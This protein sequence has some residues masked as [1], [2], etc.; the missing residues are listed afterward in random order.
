MSAERSDLDTVHS[1]H[2][3]SLTVIG[4]EL[5]AEGVISLTLADPQGGGLP[6]WAPG[7]HIDLMLDEG[8][9]RQY[10]L[11]GSPADRSQWRIAVL[12]EPESRGGSTRV[13]GLAVGD[14][15]EVRGPRNNF[16]LAPAER[17]VFVAGG[18]GVT[19]LLP[20]VSAAGADW[21]MWYGGRSRASMAFLDELDG[22]RVTVWPQDDKGLLPLAEIVASLEEGTLVYCCGPEPL[23]EA[24]EAV[25]PPGVLHVERFSP[26]AIEPSPEGDGP[27][28]VE[29][30]KSGL[31]V[32]VPA[33]ATIIEVLE[34]NGLTV[35]TSCQEGVCG[36]CETR[37]LEGI[38]DHRD[39]L[40]TEEER[41]ENEYMMVCVGRSRTPR[42]VLDL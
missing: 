27:F 12:L 8:L 3:A 6:E 9:V 36:T 28:E 2:R 33:G 22:E 23:I 20:M 14:S 40:L 37:V 34:S 38:P 29:C 30:R 41:A 32:T 10:S 24:M 13:H 11:C 35:L 4:R 15:V 16:P 5:V 42:L 39:S 7:A 19:P 18:I 26:K 21:S 1:D 31:V 17:Y 25:C